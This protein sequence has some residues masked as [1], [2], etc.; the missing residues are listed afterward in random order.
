MDR[1]DFHIGD[2]LTLDDT[3]T[4][5]LRDVRRAKVGD[6]IKARNS[7]NPVQVAEVD[8]ID[9]TK[10]SMRI[11]VKNLATINSPKVRIEL[12]QGYPK[13]SK[14]EDV[15]RMS[16]EAGVTKVIPVWTQYADIRHQAG[17]Q[18]LD[19][20]IRVAR[21]AV[22]QSGNI[23]YMTTT[24]AIALSE[25]F[26]IN[27]PNH[28]TLEVVCHP[29]DHENRLL[30]NFFQH[31]SHLQALHEQTVRIFVGPEGGFSPSEMEE[32]QKRGA[33]AYSFGDTIIRTEHAGLYAI[34]GIKTL[35]EYKGCRV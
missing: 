31:W 34:A 6:S 2:V 24:E 33:L 30:I 19:R 15:L 9:I 5:H 27:E 23:S 8:I 11:L 21:E 13:S 10:Q 14:F 16:I 1:A 3:H 32:F 7:A 26:S 17:M 18:K 4:R 35:I 28:E 29:I 22:E 25:F 20:W 12:V